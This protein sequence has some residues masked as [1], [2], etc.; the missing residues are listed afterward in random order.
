MLKF[1]LFLECDN[2]EQVHSVQQAA[3]LI[4]EDSLPWPDLSQT[5]E[6]QTVFDDLEVGT[7]IS[8][9]NDILLYRKL[10]ILV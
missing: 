3:I 5:I 9:M 8:K 2:R 1:S 7:C 6:S 10:F 4:L